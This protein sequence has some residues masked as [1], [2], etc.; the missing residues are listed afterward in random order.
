[1]GRSEGGQL[2]CAEY[3]LCTQSGTEHFYVILTVAGEVERVIFILLM[4]KPTLRKVISLLKVIQ[5]NCSG[6]PTPSTLR[7]HRTGPVLLD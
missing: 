4:R 6:S 1:M 3:L 2:P 7:L 5:L